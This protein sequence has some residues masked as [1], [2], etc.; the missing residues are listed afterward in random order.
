MI[1]FNLTNTKPLAIVAVILGGV[2]II[3]FVVFIFGSLQK[4]KQTPPE[5]SV[6]VKPSFPPLTGAKLPQPKGF[7]NELDKIKSILPYQGENYT[8]EYRQ[9]LNM[10]GV[11]I[12]AKSRDEYI[13]IRQNAEG[14][15]KSKGV[16]DLCA[17]NILWRTPDDPR[18]RESLNAKDTITSGCPAGVN[19]Q[20]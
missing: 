5:T 20:P 9:T 12:N 16:S 17:L 8:I 3:A 14:S 10:I 19:P 1:K 15:L 18:V 7:E 4:A 6:P 13:Q 2:L 11:R